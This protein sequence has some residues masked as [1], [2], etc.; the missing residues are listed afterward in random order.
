M[1]PA[2]IFATP[3]YMLKHLLQRVNTKMCSPN[4]IDIQVLLFLTSEPSKVK[5]CVL[6]SCAPNTLL[7]ILI[8][9]LFYLPGIFSFPIVILLRSY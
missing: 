5:Y 2:V 1:F 3:I 4:F 7:G 8:P 6:S 9:S